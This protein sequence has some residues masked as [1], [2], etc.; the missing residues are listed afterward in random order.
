MSAEQRALKNPADYERPFDPAE[1]RREFSART[2]DSETRAYFDRAV[3]GI[4]DRGDPLSIARAVS[5]RR[6]MED[7]LAAPHDAS[8]TEFGVTSKLGDSMLISFL[9]DRANRAARP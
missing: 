7:A 8:L 6:A 5:Q 2:R 4:V 3:D 9:I 1:V